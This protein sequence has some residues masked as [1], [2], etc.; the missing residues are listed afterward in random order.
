LGIEIKPRPEEEKADLSLD[1]HKFI[2]VW[3]AN[4]VYAFC[5]EKDDPFSHEGAK[6]VLPFNMIEGQHGLHL[7][8]V[9][10]DRNVGKSS[11]VTLVVTDYSARFKIIDGKIVNL[12][13]NNAAVNVLTENKKYSLQEEGS[14]PRFSPDAFLVS[15]CSCQIW[16]QRDTGMEPK[17]TVRTSNIDFIQV[18]NGSW[19]LVQNK[20]AQTNGDIKDTTIEAHLVYSFVGDP[21]SVPK[22]RAAAASGKVLGFARK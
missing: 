22:P 17:S 12:R 9:N 11:P 8:F 4:S 15:N 3:T 21:P 19:W 6:Y 1:G 18:E 7:N 5:P 20:G 13:N 2:E 14:F 10:G 16:G